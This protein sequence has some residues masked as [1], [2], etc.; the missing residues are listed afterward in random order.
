MYELAV[1]VGIEPSAIVSGASSLDY[2]RQ[3]TDPVGVVVEVPYWTDPRAADESPDPQGRSRRDVILPELD[4]QAASIAKVR[5]V[6]DAA[7]PL[8]PSLIADAVESFLRMD[9]DGVNDERRHEAETDADYKRTATVAEAFSVTDEHTSYRL[10]L[11]GMLRRALPAGSPVIPDVD[12][13]LERW[14]A[15]ARDES[16]AE[17]IPIHQLVAVQAGAILAAVAHANANAESP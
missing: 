13:L 15:E 11:L 14:S 16:M 2:A 5:A 17:A 4:R 7:A 12:D 6:Y 9:G 1:A 3:Y 8:P 10:R